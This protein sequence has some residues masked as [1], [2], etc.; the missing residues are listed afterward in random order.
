MTV[1]RE[2][3]AHGVAA[4]GVAGP[5]GPGVVAVTGGATGLG[6][7]LLERLAARSD[8]A[9]LVGVDVRPGLVDGV[10]WRTAD[11]R[12]PL[13]AERLAGA[14]VVVHLATSYDAGQDAV[15]RR[16]LNVRG[17]A[18]VLDAALAAGV[19]RVV[20]TTS[21]DVHGAR[22]D[23]PVP[24][25]DDAP[26]HRE[27]DE[28]TLTGDHVEVERLASHAARAGLDVAVLRPATLVGGPLGPA[29]DG[30]LLAQ[31]SGTRLL[32]TRGHEPLWQLCHTDDLVA[33]LELA[34]AGEVAG[35][36]A[37]ACT[38]WLEQSRVEVLS[39][40]RRLELPPAVALSTVERLHRY[41]VAASS[42]RELDR[43]LA[44]LVVHPQRL[45]DA[46]WSPS[47]TNEEALLAHLAG[48]GPDGR[49]GAVGAAAGAVA[50]LS[51]AALVRAARRKRRRR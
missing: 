16:A 45:L 31:L 24:L 5:A 27:P 20:L 11:V 8:L 46:G 51:T 37:V 15:E 44:P 38:G 13:L 18:Q 10:V 49:A 9:G 12:D 33:A 17:T 35:P 4:T 26:L 48:R 41:G 29:Y 3:T 28:S 39:G 14:D 21:A 30:Q 47:W 19:R 42:R 1:R 2:R 22:P 25:P 34:A 7:A 36:L 40:Q 23:N 6:R 50:L 32:A 43:V